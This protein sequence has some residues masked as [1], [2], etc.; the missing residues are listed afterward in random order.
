MGYVI[1][2]LEFNNLKNITKY[3]PDFYSLYEQFKEPKLENEI[4]EVGAV[5]LDKMMNCISQ[6][7]TYVKPSAL[8]VLN[9]KITEIT[10]ITDENL[11]LGITFS[12]AMDKLKKFVDDDSIICSWAKDDIAEIFRNAFYHN[13]NDVSWLKEYLDIQEYVTKILGHKKALSLKNALEELKIKVDESKLHDALNDAV[14]T[15][16][17]FKR[18][19]NNR[20]VKS[21]IVKDVYNM[22]A[23]M[24]KDLQ[25]YKIDIS[26]L[27]YKCPKCKTNITVERPL[28]LFNWRFMGIGKCPKCNTKVLQEVIVK[29]TISGDEVYNNVNSVLNDIEYTDYYYKFEKAN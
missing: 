23:I 17:V 27:D 11:R 10:G 16:E 2:D 8:N 7:K 14:Y 5:K 15:S 1:L 9:P 28:K 3:Y 21:Y 20:I 18:L 12:E 4:I 26:K 6:F 13:Y 22:P 29:K 24:I 19:F 25:N